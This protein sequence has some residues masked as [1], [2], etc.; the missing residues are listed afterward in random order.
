M[1]FKVWLIIVVIA[2]DDDD[3]ELL[4]ANSFWNVIIVQI[5]NEIIPKII[6]A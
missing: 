5:T 3:D 1:I 2:E 4:S 6:N